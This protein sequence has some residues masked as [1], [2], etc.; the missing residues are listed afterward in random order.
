MQGIGLPSARVRHRAAQ[1]S[2]PPSIVHRALDRRA[3]ALIWETAKPPALHSSWSGSLSPSVWLSHRG[4][5]K[6]QI[7][8]FQCGRFR[9]KSLGWVGQEWGSVL[10]QDLRRDS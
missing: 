7:L 8:R 1:E 4:F 6:G 2:P 5:F 10:Y 9:F 3:R